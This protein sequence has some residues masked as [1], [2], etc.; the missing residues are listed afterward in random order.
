MKK[1]KLIGAISLA[2]IGVIVA[3]SLPL[4]SYIQYQNYLAGID[5]AG[6]KSTDSANE[7]DKGSNIVE[8]NVLV[9]ITAKLKDGV[10]YF[11]NYRAEPKKDDFDVVATYQKGSVTEEETIYGDQFEMVVPEN[12][13]TEGGVITFSF[14]GKSAQLAIELVKVALETIKVTKKPY[15]IYYKEGEK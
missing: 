10:R 1:I 9:S 14:K 4:S 13:R 3:G 11:D 12:F 8:Q 2:S 6:N 7:N 5:V 15:I